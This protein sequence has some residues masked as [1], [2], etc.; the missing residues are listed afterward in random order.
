[1]S[2]SNIAVVQKV[3]E[4]F[5]TGVLEGIE[6]YMASDYLNHASPDSGCGQGAEE[7]KASVEWVRSAFSELEIEVKELLCAADRVVA[8]VVVNG[9]HTGDYLDFAS[10]GR[11]VFAEH[12]HFFRVREGK[13]VEHRMVSDRL[14]ALMRLGL[15]P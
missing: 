8:R 1:M 14:G 5:Q 6:A 13:I 12:V 10:T 2:L 3:F 9:R 7:F 15:Y 11:R 4:A